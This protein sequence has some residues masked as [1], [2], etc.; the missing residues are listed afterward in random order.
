MAYNLKYE[1]LFGDVEGH[2]YKLEI[3]ERDYSGSVLDAKFGSSPIKIKYDGKDNGYSQIYGSSATIQIYEETKNQYD[4]LVNTEEKQHKVVLKYLDSG[5]TYRNY[6]LGF[7]VADRMTRTIQQLPNLLVFRAFDGIALLENES[8]ILPNRSAVNQ[9][10]FNVMFHF[11]LGQL[12]FEDQA[13]TNTDSLEIMFANNF[14]RADKITDTSLTL[15]QKLSQSSLLTT[16]EVSNPHAMNPNLGLFN[17]KQQLIQMLASIGCR[18]YQAGGKWI[19]E[20]NNGQLDAYLQNQAI[21]N[22]NSSSSTQY[23]GI[24]SK[25]NNRIQNTLRYDT[26]FYRFSAVT[27]GQFA[28]QFTEDRIQIVPHDLKPLTLK[29]EFEPQ[30]RSIENQINI[31]SFKKHH[32]FTNSSFEYGNTN[33]I[34]VVNVAS[35]EG[36]SW[37]TYGGTLGNYDQMF[38]Q[39]GSTYPAQGIWQF[40]SQPP[41]RPTKQGFVENIRKNGKQSF[42]TNIMDI[43]NNRRFLSIAGGNVGSSLGISGQNWFFR[44]NLSANRYKIKG[45]NVNEIKVKISLFTEFDVIPIAIASTDVN[46]VRIPYRIYLYQYNSNGTLNQTPFKIWA[47]NGRQSFNFE[48][49]NQYEDGDQWDDFVPNNQLPAPRFN[50]ELRINSINYNKWNTFEATIASPFNEDDSRADDDFV[51]SFQLLPPT[52]LNGGTPNGNGLNGYNSFDTTQPEG[53]G[54]DSYNYQ[55]TNDFMSFYKGLYIDNL[56]IFTKEPIDSPKTFECILENNPRQ[57]KKITIKEARGF[58]DFNGDEISSFDNFNTKNFVRPQDVFGSASDRIDENGNF[59]QARILPQLIN[60]EIANN[61]RKRLKT[62]E[63]EFKVMDPNKRP[64]FFSDR[65][66]FGWG[67][68]PDATNPDFSNVDDKNVVVLDKMTFNPKENTY[69]IKGHLQDQSGNTGDV[70]AINRVAVD[71]NESDT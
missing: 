63:G 54:S 14:F 51:I 28:S 20:Q 70:D 33:L 49:Q 29:E 66:Y 27:G 38:G 9:T 68:D 48:H 32:L 62:Y 1:L 46:E 55:Q 10:A 12:N 71:I 59:K 44:S 52:P 2:S 69:K 47:R 24:E 26:R 21:I 6:W 50:N 34:N 8:M 11:I 67:V 3:F 31:K 43:A 30:I 7:I 35:S 45:F 17:S 64:M 23:D 42:F 16:M 57:S 13:G 5:G 61:H 56:E 25:I 19:I 40:P 36:W 60:Q 53:S 22:T 39:N 15:T 65:L 4:D 18:L 37:R 58:G 41:Y